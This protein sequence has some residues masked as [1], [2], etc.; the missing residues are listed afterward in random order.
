MHLPVC[1]PP[2]P[3]HL[4]V[5]VALCPPMAIAAEL[6][7]HTERLP[8]QAHSD[9]TAGVVVDRCTER[10]SRDFKEDLVGETLRRIGWEGRVVKGGMQAGCGVE[11]IVIVTLTRQRLGE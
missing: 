5:W 6:P 4:P 10:N 7:A 8:W 9:Y 3:M 2:P 11:A 1:F